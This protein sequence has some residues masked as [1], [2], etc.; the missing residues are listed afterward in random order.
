MSPAGI[1]TVRELV[2]CFSEGKLLVCTLLVPS[3]TCIFDFVFNFQ[4]QLSH[5][6]AK[7]KGASEVQAMED[8]LPS[9]LKVCQV[10]DV[11]FWTSIYLPSLSILIFLAYKI[12]WT[13]TI[14]NHVSAEC[15]GNENA[16]FCKGKRVTQL[17]GKLEKEVAKLS[18][19]LKIKKIVLLRRTVPTDWKYKSSFMK[20]QLYHYHFCEHICSTFIC[21][22]GYRSK[23]FL[24]YLFWPTNGPLI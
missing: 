3:L 13:C 23:M 16:G 5:N 2:A 14:H 18:C 9:L 12:L 21:I 17:Q 1:P 22:F 24:S 20:T 6:R 15:S 11:F 7:Y 19:S 10:R 8:L 4:I